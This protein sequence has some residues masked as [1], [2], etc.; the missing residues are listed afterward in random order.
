MR[1][2]QWRS[3]ENRFSSFLFLLNASQIQTLIKVYRHTCAPAHAHAH[4]DVA[5][6][7]AVFDLSKCQPK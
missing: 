7:K 6:N 3:W 2:C 5:L 1:Y 4:A